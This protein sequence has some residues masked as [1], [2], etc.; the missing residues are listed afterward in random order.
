MLNR[1]RARA[2]AKEGFTLIELLVVV[3]IIG[4]LAAIAIPSFLGQRSSAQNAGAQSLVRNAQSTMEAYFATGQAYTGAA[5]ATL[6]PLEPNIDWIDGTAAAAANDRVG[7]TGVGANAYALVTQ[8]RSGNWYT[9][10][11]IA[12]GQSY[13]C[14]AASPAAAPDTTCTAN[15]W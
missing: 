14:L 11:R 9:V 5:D 6:S 1:I 8:A 3:I 7:I 12:A 4:I 10:R 13:R 15:E 2:T